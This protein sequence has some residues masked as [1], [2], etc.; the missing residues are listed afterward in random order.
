RKETTVNRVY[1]VG[2]EA[3]GARQWL[4]E[5]TKDDNVLVVDTRLK[6]WS[7]RVDFRETELKATYGKR[8][9]QA[10]PFLGNRGYKDGYID[11]ADPDTGIRGLIAYLSEG[12]DL[13]LLCGCC[14]YN[15]CHRATIVDLLF[16][17]VNVEVIQPPVCVVESGAIK[18]I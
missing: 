9:K 7:W 6:P 11:I 8:Y 5:L 4:D 1:P 13:I 2:Y 10:G 12:Y 14:D 15:D 3:L 16:Q 18:T 17:K